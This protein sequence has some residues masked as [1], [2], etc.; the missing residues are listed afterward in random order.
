[1][2]GALQKAPINKPSFK[3]ALLSAGQNR[4]VAK[5]FANG[6]VPAPMRLGR[7]PSP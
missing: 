5:V 6:F 7:V 3:K 2:T 1:M 4:G